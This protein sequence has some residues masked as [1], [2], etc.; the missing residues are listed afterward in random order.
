VN[1]AE[2]GFS[3]VLVVLLLILAGYFGWRQIQTL[4]GLRRPSDESAEDRK[5]LRRQAIRRLVC[6]GLMLLLAG[7]LVGTLFLEPGYQEMTRDLERDGPEAA[8][9]EHKA[10]ARFFTSYWIAI[11]FVL[12]ALIALAGFDFWAIARYGM[13][14]RRQLK[15]DHRALLHEEIARYR[16][17]RNG[18]GEH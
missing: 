5:Y 12:F 2:F 9:Q 7:L 10:F 15:A 4:R 13:R 11:L 18:E 8:S 17:Q 3:L 14:H 1:P 16:R 6:C